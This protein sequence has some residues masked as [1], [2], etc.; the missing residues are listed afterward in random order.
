MGKLILVRHGKSLWNKE[1]RF[2]GWIDIDL[3]IAGEKEAE[4]AGKQIRK[5]NIAIDLAYS[6]IFKRA[7][8][9]GK[10]ILDVLAQKN[11]EI[12][13]DWRLNER[14]Y[15]KLQGLNKS[16]IE[17]EYGTKQISLWRRDYLTKPPP[18]SRV[19]IE[20]LLK[21]TG[22]IPGRLGTGMGTKTLFSLNEQHV[23]ANGQHMFCKRTTRF[24]NVP[25]VC[26]NRQAMRYYLFNTRTRYFSQ[27]NNMCL[28]THDTFF[29]N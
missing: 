21:K 12:K 13:Q 6:S 3:D 1:N 18:I 19:D 26:S 22:L 10:I 23:S 7:Y 25:H 20:K 5:K 8:K 29:A 27:M 11:I 14:H 9:T 24:S 15:G 17:K 4:D 16:E 2:T 28:Q